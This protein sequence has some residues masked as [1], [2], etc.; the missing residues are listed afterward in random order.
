MNSRMKLVAAVTV[1]CAYLVAVLAAAFVVTGS[2]LEG[3][4]QAVMEAVLDRRLG[5]VLMIVFFACVFSS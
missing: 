3:Q 1:A 4:E 5:A 2:G